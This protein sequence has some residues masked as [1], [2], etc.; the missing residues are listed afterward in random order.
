[1]KHA[2]TLRAP[3][4]LNLGLEVCGRRPDG[5]HD[6]VT[7]FQT[8]DLADLLTF[9]PASELLV[10]VNGRPARDDN[11]IVRA[12]RALREATGTTAG[13][14]I[15][16]VKKVPVAAGLG[17]GSSDAAA[18]LRGLGRL[19]GRTL[20]PAALTGL[21]KG[22]GADVPFFLRGGGAFASG[23][24][25]KLAPVPP[26]QGITFVVVTPPGSV[27]RDKT[28]TLYQALT[29]YDYSNGEATRAQAARLTAGA[30][31]DPGLLRNAFERPA[32]AIF[33]GS[34]TWRARFLAAG[35]PWVLL[36]GSG[37]TLFAGLESKS[38]ACAVAEKLA[39][40]GAQCFITAPVNVT[41]DER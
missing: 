24:G 6:L 35:A 31:L 27:P 2:L 13:A 37:P 26:L 29:T 16:V 10:S 28:R 21:A 38:A 41:V 12:A 11:L 30:G 17:G 18:T 33:T 7:I 20:P 39:S 36:A 1:M 15:E 14:A 5:Y 32:G 8:I 9:T 34:E 3:A 22:L 4:K 23:I 19:W 25:D 40:E